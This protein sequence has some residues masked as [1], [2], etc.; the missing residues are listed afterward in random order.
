MKAL[1]YKLAMQE[2]GEAEKWIVKLISNARL[3]A[4]IDSQEGRIVM[5]TP[6]NSVHRLVVDKTRDLAARTCSMVAQFE[7]M[8]KRKTYQ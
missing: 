8:G 1:S 3:D 6:Q 4:K 7:R 2:D 5:G